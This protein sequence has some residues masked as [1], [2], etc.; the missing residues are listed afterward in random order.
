MHKNTFKVDYRLKCWTLNHK[1][2]RR[3]LGN[4]V[5][6]IAHSNVLSEISP[7]VRETKEKKIHGIIPN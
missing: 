3:K 4:K 6:D 5:L 1:N 2:S 7:Q